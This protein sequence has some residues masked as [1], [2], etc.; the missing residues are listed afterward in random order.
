LTATEEDH[1]S[2]DQVEEDTELFRDR[3]VPD[4]IQLDDAEMHADIDQDASELGSPNTSFEANFPRPEVDLKYNTAATLD[5]DHDMEDENLENGPR[6]D[7]P[8]PPLLSWLA[9][10][11]SPENPT[12]VQS[13]LQEKK[14]RQEQVKAQ[15]MEDIELF[16]NVHVVPSEREA[17]EPASHSRHPNS[18]EVELELAARIYYRNIVDRYPAI[19]HYLA[20][21]LAEANL[22][23]AKRLLVSKT[24]ATQK[25]V[26]RTRITL[27]CYDTEDEI[28]QREEQKPKTFL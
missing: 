19:P 10:T 26:A 12:M 21:R 28:R 23:R 16:R 18:G 1:V 4:D 25:E 7:N 11:E 5:E 8:Q 17:D 27:K 14:S 24:D 15:E 3:E 13:Q 20:R 2:Q 6:G 22:S 9:Q